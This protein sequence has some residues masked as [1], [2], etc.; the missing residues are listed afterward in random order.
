MNE[1]EDT[2]TTSPG[3]TVDR[4]RLFAERLAPGSVVALY[5]EL[6]SGKTHFAKG[7]CAGL[8]VDPKSVTSP[9]FSLINEYA[10]GRLPIYHFDTYRLRSVQEFMS[11]GYEDYFEGHGVCL[12]EW[13]EPIEALLPE[14]V[15]RVRLTHVGPERRNIEFCASEPNR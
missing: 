10:G 3:E 2:V 14:D 9:T 8:G 11:L 6:G 12:I 1:T 5:G 4:G 15:I 13:P 7:L